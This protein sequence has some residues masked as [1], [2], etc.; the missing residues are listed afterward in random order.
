MLIDSKPTVY[1]HN[2]LTAS[3]GKHLTH[4]HVIFDACSSGTN[5]L[6]NSLI[7]LPL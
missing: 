3:A 1:G 4:L 2:L 7:S 5:P 6:I